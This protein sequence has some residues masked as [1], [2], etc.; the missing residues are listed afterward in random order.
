M[1]KRNIAAIV[2]AAGKGTR[3]NSDLPKVLHPLAGRPMLGYVLETVAGLKPAKIAVVV[4]ADGEAVARVASPYPTVIQKQ[5]SG[6]G[7]AVKA[8]R[9]MLKGFVGDVLIVYGDSPFLTPDT[10]ERMLAVR[11]GKNG[12]SVIVLGFRPDDPTGYGRLVTSAGSKLEAIVEH[13]DATPAQR[14]I[15]LC[16]SGVMVVDG[17][18]LFRLLDRVDNVNAKREFYLTDIVKLARAGGLGCGYVE[19]PADE[20]LGID[21]RAKLAA[22]E[23]QMQARLRQAAMEAGASLIDPT[24]P[25]AAGDSSRR[26][27]SC[28]QLR[29]AQEHD[30]RRGSQGQSSGLSRRYQ[31]RRQDQYRRRH[32]HLQL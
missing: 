30:A 9:A 27:R 22:A 13:R 7:D 1:G 28:R 10:L 31:H 4:A 14:A 20:L 15:P 16:N 32:H 24:S 5:P 25:A 19:A 26:R 2:L 11:R 18:E 3:M 12:P 8:A 6:T 21:S 17:G 23:A 29:R